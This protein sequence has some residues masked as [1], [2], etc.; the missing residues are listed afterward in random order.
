[1][2]FSED[3]GDKPASTVGP[4]DKSDYPMLHQYRAWILPD[5]G[6]SSE[7]RKAFFTD[8]IIV[9]D[10][11][12]LLDLYRYTPGARDELLVA[13][14]LVSSRI[15]LPYQVGIEFVRGRSGVIFDRLET[16]KRARAEIDRAFNEAWRDIEGSRDQVKTLLSTYAADEQSQT[17]LDEL[18]TQPE[19]LRL[20]DSWL[21]RLRDHVKKLREDQDIKLNDIRFGSD[22]ILPQ[23]AELYGDQIAPA[24]SAEKIKERVQHASDFRY[25]NEIPPG[26]S[27]Q[28]KTTELRAA[29]DFLLWEE[30]ISHAREP[31][32]SRRIMFVS[33]DV[34]EDWYEQAGPGVER[35]PWPSLLDEFRTRT[36]KELLIIETSEFFG[37]VKDHLNAEFTPQTVREIERSVES[38]ELPEEPTAVVITGDEAPFVQ[39]P[40]SLT[41]AAFQAARLSSPVIRSALAD[42]IHRQFQWWLIGVTAELQLRIRAENEPVVNIDSITRAKLPPSPDWL[43]GTELPQGG[44]P[45]RSSFWAAPWMVEVVNATPGSDRISLLRLALRQLTAR[46]R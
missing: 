23:I 5:S 1:M 42:P 43:P 14:R 6:H 12:V 27:D 18:I 34:K 16:L 25:P 20:L 13:L 24:P 3:L 17:A 8:G 44:L 4:A 28:G 10:T 7:E 38:N 45:A 22:P 33:R 15:W 21:L 36:G 29:G 9:L 30:I 32:T 39:P 2:T 19:L 35:R 31:N 11:N 37:G 40:R 26:F 41:Q 46:A